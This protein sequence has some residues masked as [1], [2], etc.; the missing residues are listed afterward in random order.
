MYEGRCHFLYPHEMV[1]QMVIK[2]TFGIRACVHAR[3]RD[4][5]IVKIPTRH[6]L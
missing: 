1:Q 3:V 5:S 2:F 6:F 4:Q